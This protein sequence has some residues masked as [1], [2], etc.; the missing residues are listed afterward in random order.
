MHPRWSK[1]DDSFIDAAAHAGSLQPYFLWFIKSR[2]WT[3]FFLIYMCVE[4]NTFSKEATKLVVSNLKE[5][6]DTIRHHPNYCV[7]KHYCSNTWNYCV[8]I[9]VFHYLWLFS[10]WMQHECWMIRPF[11]FSRNRKGLIYFSYFSPMLEWIKKLR[12]QG[13]KGSHSPTL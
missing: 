5:F 1:F 6:N 7:M 8:I 11:S 3:F 4:L 10:T 12:S 2:K 13:R 9:I